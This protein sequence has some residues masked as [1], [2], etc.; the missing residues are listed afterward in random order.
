MRVVIV[1]SVWEGGWSLILEEMPAMLESHRPNGLYIRSC[2]STDPS[3]EPTTMPDRFSIS[4]PSIRSQNHSKTSQNRL[5]KD[6]DLNHF[7]NFQ[8]DYL[9]AQTIFLL[10][11]K[12]WTPFHTFISKGWPLRSP[13]GLLRF[14]H[15]RIQEFTPL[16]YG[17]YDN[18]SHVRLRKSNAW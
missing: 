11:I 5:V 9:R 10:W 8:G 4:K 14:E 13:V 12:F 16:S 2:R 7:F 1:E 3:W 18:Y 6:A 17:F 15:C